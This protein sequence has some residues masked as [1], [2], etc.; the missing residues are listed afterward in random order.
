MYEVIFILSVCYPL[1]KYIT[2]LQMAVAGSWRSINLTHLAPLRV[3][4]SLTVFTRVLA[5]C[6]HQPCQGNL[7]IVLDWQIK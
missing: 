2:V 7:K 4:S 6:V 3:C 1:G 5:M